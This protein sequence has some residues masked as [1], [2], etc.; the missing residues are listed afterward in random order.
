LPE[1]LAQALS[2]PLV[3]LTLLLMSIQ[4]PHLAAVSVLRVLPLRIARPA[5]RG[6]LPVCN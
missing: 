4:A 5:I 1:L 2:V 3:P 6:L